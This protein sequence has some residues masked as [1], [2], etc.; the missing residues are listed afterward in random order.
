[1]FDFY[2][3]CGCC[4]AT[5]DEEVLGISR[6]DNETEICEK[7]EEKEAMDEFSSKIN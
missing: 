7:C 3:V 4:G 1:M 2:K 6:T 5:T